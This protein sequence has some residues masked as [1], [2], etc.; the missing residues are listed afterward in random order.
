VILQLKP[1]GFTIPVSLFGLGFLLIAL[2]EVFYLRDVFD[3]RLNTLFKIYY[4]VWILFGLSSAVAIFVLVR[5]LVRPVARVATAATVAT[6]VVILLA[7]PALASWQW[8]R[9]W[10]WATEGAEWRGLDGLAFARERYP[11]EA[12]AIDW[13]AANAAP[14]DVIVE[15]P[16]CSYQPVGDLP[17]NRISAYTGIPAVIGWPGH[18]QQWRG[19]QPALI[20]AIAPRQADVAVIYGDPGSPLADRYGVRWM[21]DGIYERGDGAGGCD[22]TGPY[23]GMADPGWPGPDWSPAFQQG[24]ITI[25]ERR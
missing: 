13:L 14:G 20:G 9:D 19:G 6:A 25:W 7:Y 2:V 11:D 15:A 5:R 23:P 17:T 3:S 24:S 16:G 22:S 18:E 12:A 1:D 10:S 8:A 4:Q 21:I